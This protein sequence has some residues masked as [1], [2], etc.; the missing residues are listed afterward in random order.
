M[1]ATATLDVDLKVEPCVEGLDSSTC[2]NTNFA[3]I[4]TAAEA[5]TKDTL[6]VPNAAV[7]TA[8]AAKEEA[9]SE[10]S[11]PGTPGTPGT[12]ASPGGTEEEDEEEEEGENANIN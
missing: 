10:P 3:D 5:I 2:T 7:T 9:A 11:T 1:L 8:T 4:V 6:T 12:P